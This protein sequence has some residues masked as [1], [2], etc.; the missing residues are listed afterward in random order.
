MYKKLLPRSADWKSMAYLLGFKLNTVQ[1]ISQENPGDVNTC[2]RII[3]KEWVQ[4]YP[5]RSLKD[6]DEALNSLQT[7][8]IVPQTRK[9]GCHWFYILSV[10]ILVFVVIILFLLVFDIYTSSLLYPVELAPLDREF[11]YQPVIHKYT[12]TSEYN[13]SVNRTIVDSIEL[14]ELRFVHLLSRIQEKLHKYIATDTA[15][16]VEVLGR[17][18]S[19]LFSV[20]Y[21]PV[22]LHQG[23]DQIDTLFEQIKQFFNF[24]DTNLLIGLDKSFLSGHFSS[25]LASYKELLDQFKTSTPII[26]LIDLVRTVHTEQN[27]T[28]IFLKLGHNWNKKNFENLQKFKEYVFGADASLMRLISIHHSVLTVTYVI[29][30]SLELSVLSKAQRNVQLLK[31]S[32]LNLFVGEVSL[33]NDTNSIQYMNMYN[34]TSEALC[35]ICHTVNP[36]DEQFSNLSIHF[37]VAIGADVNYLCDLNITPLMVTVVKGNKAAVTTLLNLNANPNIVDPASGM[38]MLLLAI[39]DNNIE[40][41][42]ILLQHKA[43]PNI[44]L[45]YN[46]DIPVNFTYLTFRGTY[47]NIVLNTIGHI[48]PLTSP[49]TYKF[50]LIVHMLLE[51][52]ADPNYQSTVG[53]P[54]HIAAFVGCNDCVEIL[55]KFNGD[56]NVNSSL[57]MTPLDFAVS[58]NHS[59]TVHTLLQYNIDHNVTIDYTIY[60]FH[61]AVNCYDAIFKIILIVSGLNVNF[62]ING[63]TLL[64]VTSEQNCLPIIRYLFKHNADPMVYDEQGQ[65]SLHRCIL[66]GYIECVKMHLEFGVDPNIRTKY[67][68]GCTP[69]FIAASREHLEIMKLLLKKNAKVNSHSH[70]GLVLSTYF[71]E[72]EI[73]QQG[74][75]Y[76]VNMLY[77]TGISPLFKS[78]HLNRVD[79]VKLLLEHGADPNSC[80]GTFSALGIAVYL[81]QFKIIEMLLEHN[82]S[83]NGLYDVFPPLYLAVTLNHVNIVKTFLDQGADVNIQEKHHGETL[84]M[85]AAVKGNV[86]MVELLLVNGAD[87]TITSDHITAID[88]VNYELVNIFGY[89]SLNIEIARRYLMIKKLLSFYIQK[90]QQQTDNESEQETEDGTE[91]LLSSSETKHTH[92]NSSIYEL[93][94]EAEYVLKNEYS[95]AIGK[96]TDSLRSFTMMRNY[97]QHNLYFDDFLLLEKQLILYDQQL[98]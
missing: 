9:N 18:L 78:I 8:N 10:I 82:A 4:K 58:S 49:D 93:V 5:D 52:G 32:V 57:G 41:V 90:Q 96:K 20:P 46:D 69:L 55:L 91:Q 83:V 25:S 13:I 53:S 7:S 63:D 48:T 21:K 47:P 45:N 36:Q 38:S 65:T 26:N 95:S 37:L 87:P 86:K 27:N 72:R 66:F 28:K 89:S 24:M 67:G 84:L 88:I 33:F 44:V 19:I 59:S 60:L 64:F 2:L 77:C 12:T 35:Y 30:K 39:I 98:L 14:L 61:A 62:T 81:Q 85:V 29:P 80:L 31:I 75:F 42:E 56:P 34:G 74:Y 73:Y 11:R 6:V 50:P 71:S 22:T 76:L 51:H 17:F 1:V 92:S 79:L 40:L 97:T 68:Y 16:K 23:I 94:Y 70:V 3:C 43:N 54:L 15:E